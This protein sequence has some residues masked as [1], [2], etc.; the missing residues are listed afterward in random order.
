MII[1]IEL[2]PKLRTNNFEFRS[3]NK[4]QLGNNFEMKNHNP[5]SLLSNFNKPPQAPNIREENK[6]NNST[7]KHKK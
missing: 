2:V 3:K 6:A 1:G 7:I 5:D 4:I